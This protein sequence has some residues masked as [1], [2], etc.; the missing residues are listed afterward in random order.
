MAL[1]GASLFRRFGRRGAETPPASA[2]ALRLIDEKGVDRPQVRVLISALGPDLPER[3]VQLRSAAQAV[4]AG[5]QQPVLAT[6]H[7]D[8]P[9]VVG[10]TLPTEILPTR[11]D[12]KVLTDAE[13]RSYLNR[14]WTLILAKWDIDEAIDLGQG[15]EEFLAGQ[16]PAPARDT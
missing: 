2:S 5:G 6:S 16:C 3:E 14:R 8:A 12:L 1:P 7:A 4:L 13:Y 11:A 9:F 15:F 10:Q